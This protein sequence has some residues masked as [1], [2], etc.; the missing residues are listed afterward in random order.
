M[1]FLI[2]WFLFAIVVGIAASSRGRSGFG[3]FLLSCLISPLLGLILVL[4]LAKNEPRRGDPPP[5]YVPGP[6]ES[7]R[8]CPECAEWIQ[9]EARKCKHCGST[10][11]QPA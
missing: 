2:F 9:K 6:G 10:V 3:W 7:I 5:N 8:K 11:Q 1:E 4:V